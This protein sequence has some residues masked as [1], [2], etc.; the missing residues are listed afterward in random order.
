MTITRHTRRRV[1]EAIPPE[2]APLRT[3]QEVSKVHISNVRMVCRMLMEEGQ[4]VTTRAGTGQ[5]SKH[6]LWV[7]LNQAACDK[8]LDSWAD[9]LASRQKA[10]QDAR[11]EKRRQA[12]NDNTNL[13]NIAAAAAR[14]QERKRRQREDEKR[15]K[16]LEDEKR[17]KTQAKLR[18][19]TAAAGAQVFKAGTLSPKP[20]K[21]SDWDK[22]APFVMPDGLE[23]IEISNTI[24]HRHHVEPDE[25]PPLFS[26]LRPG[27]YID[28][29]P[30]TW[31]QAA[32]RA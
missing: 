32:T 23:I 19:Q 18:K 4:I 15:A 30:R 28:N 17:K 16:E 10:R 14:R 3:L 7:F 5:D 31:V 29:A 2:G 21:P 8:F 12:R 25:V 24:K 22:A 20:K 13:S 1:Y 9:E 26:S 27:Q 11:I 6:E